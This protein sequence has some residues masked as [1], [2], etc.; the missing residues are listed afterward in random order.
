MSWSY[1]PTNLENHLNWIRLR[2]GDTDTNDQQLS[3]EEITSLLSLHDN[4]CLA[5]AAAAGMIAAKYS[6]YGAQDEAEVFRVL[7]ATIYAEAGPQYLC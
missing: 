5:A 7:S 6:R 2:I 4:K 3:D 1:D